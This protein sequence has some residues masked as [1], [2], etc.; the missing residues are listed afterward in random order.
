LPPSPS[1][2]RWPPGNACS[3]RR[4]HGRPASSSQRPGV[5]HRRQDQPRVR[6]RAR[7][8]SP[9][10][11]W[12][13]RSVWGRE[14]PWARRG[15][16]VCSATLGCGAVLAY[17][18]RSQALARGE[19]VP[20]RRRSYC[21][22]DASLSS[23]TSVNRSPPAAAGQDEARPA[24]ARRHCDERVGRC[25]SG[26]LGPLPSRRSRARPTVPPRRLRACHVAT[27]TGN[28]PPLSRV[29]PLADDREKLGRAPVRGARADQS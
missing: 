14:S 8:L 20:C 7:T 11:L 21:V 25:V 17:E 19:S 12:K 4:P 29:A 22:V 24:V 10:P 23:R 27:D 28:W 18:A 2:V 6:G 9:F 13:G 15:N 3:R 16:D 26:P 1:S 5:L